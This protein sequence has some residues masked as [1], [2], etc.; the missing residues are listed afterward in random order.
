MSGLLHNARAQALPLDGVWEFAWGDDSAWGTITVP[1]TWDAQGYTGPDG[2]RRAEG[3]GHYRRAI[4]V[5]AA[6]DGQRILLEFD[7]VAYYVEARVNG[8]PVGT[9]QG[10]WTPFAFDITA[11]ARPGAAN[12]IELDV[13]KTGLAG[14]RF[15]I[16]ESLVGFLPDVA[17]PFGGVWQSARLRAV[18]GYGL[19]D[20]RVDAD[21]ES[22]TVEVGAAVVAP[23][24]V[25]GGAQFLVEIRDRSG[26]IVTQTAQSVTDA[27]QRIKLQVADP[28]HWSPADPAL[29]RAELRLET[30]S[31]ESLAAHSVT[32]GFRAL[33]RSGTRL[34]F[35]GAPVNLRGAL[36]WGWYP[37][38]LCPAPDADTVRA[39]FRKLRALGC[40]LVK[41]CLFIPSQ[42]YFEIADEEGMFLWAELP[43]WL[44][45]VS[46]DLRA[47]APQEYAAIMAQVRHHPS[48]ILT[49]LGCELGH[50]VDAEFVRVLDDAVR[51]HTAGMLL[52]D[53]SGSGEAYGAQTADNSDFYDYHFY[54]DLHYFDPL[55]DHF[56]RDWREQRPWIFGEFCDADDYRDTAAA[57]QQHGGA[58]PWWLRDHNPI[59]A[60]SKIA[61]HEQDERM[62]RLRAARPDLPLDGAK[63]Q[64]LSRR[65]SLLIR[66]VILEKVRARAGMGGYVLT[67]IRENPL[68]TSALFDDAM[69]PKY[70][71]DDFTQF[72]TDSV[73][74]LGQGRA[75]EWRD[76]GDRPRPFD[77]WNH[78]AG[79]PLSL[80]V[81]LAHVGPRLTDGV[82]RWEVRDD[83]HA[84]VHGGEIPLSGPL[85]HG[86]PGMVASLDFTPPARD[87]AYGITLT[88][89][90]HSGEHTIRN[91]WRLWVFPPVTAWP[92][93]GLLDP[94]GSLL[95]FDDLAGAA[96]P[97]GTLAPSAWPPVVI[98]STITPALL[99]YLRGGGRVLL[100]QGDRDAPLAVQAVPFWREAIKLIGADPVMARFPH[101]GAPGPGDVAAQFYHLATDRAFDMDR[102]ADV[103]PGLHGVRSLLGRL[104]ARLFTWT[105]YLFA[106]QVGAGQIIATTLR[107]TGGEG[108]QVIGLRDNTAGRWLLYLL[109]EHGI[110][111]DR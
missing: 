33:T 5:P 64:A 65:Q 100:L 42:T 20:V 14:S 43:L 6:W 62:A 110:A 36:H 111:L 46:A 87:T 61:Y 104:D 50:D 101:D 51:P 29:Y 47:R 88:V 30:G 2:D 107:F 13:W 44:P 99:D 53:N 28:V 48:V 58:L 95:R 93:C 4:T 70:D 75:R 81:L 27:V 94:G 72:N 82:L 60:V 71:A 92:V 59:H 77:R 90:L 102:A 49:S 40:N 83:D 79:Q 84:R 85:P 106:G 67:S 68:A 3:P 98:A 89:A 39:E 31:G 97:V 38:L 54:C 91:E 56:R 25:P 7:A 66:K 63:L 24:D 57:R 37:D 45:Q 10:L 74:L 9:H 11:A 1:G 17:I 109:L 86:D 52:C 12:V 73:L 32:F 34:L 22:G 35:N 21:P 76:G 26:V 96:Q 8:Q 78:T 23:G 16:R 108:D 15:P 55:I 105:E 41:L 103:L 19:A 18:N 69:T 80:R